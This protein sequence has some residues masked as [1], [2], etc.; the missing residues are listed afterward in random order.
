MG[1]FYTNA[2]GLTQHYGTRATN[3]QAVTRRVNTNSDTQEL[4]IDFDYSHLG[5]TIATWF[6]EDKGGGATAD[7]PSGIQAYVPANAHVISCKLYVK[8]AFDSGGSATL[9]LGFYKSD[10]SVI[11]IDGIDATIAESAIDTAGKVVWC[12][13]ALSGNSGGT[14][15]PVDIGA[16]DAY[17]AGIDATAD[18]TTGEAT[19]VI[20]YR[21]ERG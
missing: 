7:S 16:D 9:T 19:L 18:F 15:L 11:D 5:T 4:R 6:S 13:G 12:D 14:E 1:T 10:G 21:M 3:E 8:T 17:V 2:D 20:E